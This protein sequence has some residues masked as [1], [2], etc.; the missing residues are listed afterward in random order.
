MVA[1]LATVLLGVLPDLLVPASPDIAWYLYVADR[2]LTGDR[3]YVDLVEINPPLIVWMKVPLAA[4]SSA[5]E[6]PAVQLYRL[7]VAVVC[8]AAAG[9][10]HQLL[11]ATLADS[12]VGERR[13]LSLLVLFVLFPL[14]R[15]DFG[16]REHLMLALVLPYI[17]LAALRS[18]RLVPSRSITV[19]SGAIAGVGLALKP[20]F[21]VVWVAIETYSWLATKRPPW[22]RTESLLSAAI[23]VLYAIVALTT[24]PEYLSLV[25]T[26][27]E[28]YGAYLRNSPMIILA[29]EAWAMFVVVALFTYLGLRTQ[30]RLFHLGWALCAAVLALLLVGLSQQ[31]GWRYHFY[32]AFALSLILLTLT[33]RGGF[34]RFRGG[35]SRVFAIGAGVTVALIVLFTVRAATL[36]IVRPSASRHQPFPEYSEL[37]RL[38]R[39]HALG[40]HVVVLS[41]NHRSA[42]PLVTN[43]GAHWG[44]RLQGVWILTGVYADEL[45]S[46]L[47]FETHPQAEMGRAERYMHSA[48]VEDIIRTQ[49][50]LIVVLRPDTS[51]TAHPAR[52]FDYLAYFGTDRCFAEWMARYSRLE[53]VGAYDVYLRRP[54]GELRSEILVAAPARAVSFAGKTGCSRQQVW[55][56]ADT[57]SLQLVR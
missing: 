49:P 51:A 46:G 9:I 5:I 3:L 24:H 41:P 17:V 10:V 42:F 19:T 36:Q 43:A 23:P 35:M 55:T 12:S 7:L 4:L 26:I 34:A 57:L 38:V 21:A 33:L 47:P 32:P 22:T 56:E 52:R 31:K 11:K 30:P 40:E 27:G 6:V 18:S 16:Q 2:V 28:A 45:M 29:N 25:A 13:L 1:V 48:V 20:H 8:G 14:S 44:L 15:E 54:P 50:K 37:S 53:S 39:E